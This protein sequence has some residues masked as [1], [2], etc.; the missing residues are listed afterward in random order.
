MVLPEKNF[1][2][3]FISCWVAIIDKIQGFKYSNS[4]QE[5]KYSGIQ[6]QITSAIIHRPEDQRGDA[7]QRVLWRSAEG[8]PP[9]FR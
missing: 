9:A 3:T 1:L 4:I 6:Y 7:A 8:S 5:F 2:P